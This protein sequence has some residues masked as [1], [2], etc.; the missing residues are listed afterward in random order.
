MTETTSPQ[1]ERNPP[2]AQQASSPDPR[3]IVIPEADGKA[4]KSWVKVFEQ[5][6]ML[7]KALVWPI[8]IAAILFIYRDPLHEISQQLPDLIAHAQKVSAGGLAIEIQA[9]AQQTGGSKLT[10]VVTELNADDVQ[11]LLRIGCGPW[12]FFGSGLHVNEYSMP[13][14]PALERFR[15]FESHGI[16]QFRLGNRIMSLKEI[17]TQ[18]KK[19]PQESNPGADQSPSLT[20]VQ[21][22]D[23]ATESQKML[24]HV[25]YELTALGRDAFGSVI[26]AVTEQLPGKKKNQKVGCVGEGDRPPH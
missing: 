21:I 6:V 23:G 11:D 1:P 26:A 20:M 8:L 17:E 7:I 22:A 13:A 19:L 10:R 25:D 5:S 18:F 14:G 4:D 9:Q 12:G 2:H 24:L 15:K 3:V 16:I